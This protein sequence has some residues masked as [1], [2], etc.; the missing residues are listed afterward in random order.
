MAD[1]IETLRQLQQLDGEIYRLRKQE[2]DKPRELEQMT[3]E[4][5]AQEATMKAAEARVT[6]LQMS[7]KDKEG[8][9][10]AREAN[11]K[12]LQGQLFQLKTNREYTTMQ[13]EISATKADNSLL[14]EA[15]LKL[16]DAIDQAKQE[17][18]VE[19]QRV[20]KEQERL[21]T[22]RTRIEGELAEIRERI[23][24][25]ERDRQ[26]LIP[27]VPPQ[28]LTVYERILAVREGL[29]LVPLLENACGGC[30][31]RMPPQVVN[32]VYLKAKLVTCENCSRI[33]YFD[34]AVSKL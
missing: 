20:A 4:V 32:E 31:R 12:K 11:V 34:D 2:Q 3:A 24:Q 9:L 27:A 14:E 13:H 25:L 6:T 30:H 33:L 26:S 10:Q 7:Q 28:T 15:I 29:A 23:S 16:F 19:Q 5:A 17:R 18:H 8:E 21:K 22:E 1:Q